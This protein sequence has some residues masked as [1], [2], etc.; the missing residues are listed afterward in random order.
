MRIVKKWKSGEIDGNR[1]N[2]FQLSKAVR[3]YIMEK[4]GC[5]CSVCGWSELNPITGKVPL[6]VHHI[7]GNASHTQENNLQVLCPNC[8]ALTPNYGK[9][10]KVGRFLRRK[11]TDNQNSRANQKR[12]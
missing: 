9:L 12:K 7:D 10:N 11:L 6:Q 5:K 1:G 4:N 2:F 8:H 3:H